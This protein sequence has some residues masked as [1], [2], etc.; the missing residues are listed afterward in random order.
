[1][2]QAG[3][4]S[5]PDRGRSFGR[6]V[7][8]MFVVLS[9]V[10]GASTPSMATEAIPYFVGL[11]A[12]LKWCAENAKASEASESACDT[13]CAQYWACNALDATPGSCATRGGTFGEGVNPAATPTAPAPVQ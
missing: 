8:A 13:Q 1:M 5:G 9:L 4:A 7:G 2:Q 12:C 3:Y 10:A 11:N 6:N